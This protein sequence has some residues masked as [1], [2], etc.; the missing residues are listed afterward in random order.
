MKN[1][2]TYLLWGIVWI[3]SV[4]GIVA[5]ASTISNFTQTVNEW[6]TIWASW[7]N[8]V[9]TRLSWT[10]AEGKMCTYAG[11]KISCTNNVP[12][13][14]ETKVWSLTEWKWCSVVSWKISCTQD[15]PSWGTSFESDIRSGV[16][17][18]TW[19][20]PGQK[21]LVS[22]YWHAQDR[23]GITVR[24]CTGSANLATTG[25]HWHTWRVWTESAVLFITAPSDGCI[26]WFTRW[27]SYLASKYMLAWSINGNFTT[28]WGWWSSS[29]WWWGGWGWWDDVW[30]DM[31]LY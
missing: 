15:A 30:W 7:F 23:W 22:V 3:F 5:W 4:T 20:I 17:Q 6:D 2:K 10:V 16:S 28:T 18:I 24:G 19:L 26:K 25:N 8:S 14:V 13:S 9:S 11:W 12:T 29:S 31:R 21:Y 27:T 1:I